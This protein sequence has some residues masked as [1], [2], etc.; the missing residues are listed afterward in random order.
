MVIPETIPLVR[1]DRDQLI[2]LAIN[3][4][5][6]AEKF[7]PAGTGRVE[8]R[9]DPDDTMIVVSVADNGP[10]IPGDEQERIFEKFHQV[11]AGKTGNPLGSG[12]GLAICRG[13]VE[14]LGG[15]IWVR[16]DLGHGST[17]FFTVPCAQP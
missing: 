8:V 4:L 5:S 2:Q 13:I 9:I 3:L 14:H 6:N 15:R 12:L 11:R 1:G 7:C 16:S 17:F 10:G